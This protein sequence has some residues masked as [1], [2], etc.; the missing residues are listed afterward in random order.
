M[1][2]INLRFTYLLTYCVQL[3]SELLRQADWDARVTHMISALISAGFISDEA[4]SDMCRAVTT[5]HRN[6]QNGINYRPASVLRAATRVTLIRSSD[7]TWQL[8]RFG[9]DYG[10]S[11]V[12]DGETDV[13]I[14][15]GTH[16]SIVSDVDDKN[17]TRL[18]C[19]LDTVLS[20][21]LAH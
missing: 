1:R 12:Y 3:S 19:L 4:R 18:A 5:Y 20:S 2:Y 14:I 7:S 9:E 17:S 11:A 8:A 6:I 16:D 10:L 21:Q 15:P 13:H